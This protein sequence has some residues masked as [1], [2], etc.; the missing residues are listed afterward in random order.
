MDPRREILASNFEV[1][2][3]EMKQSS[4]QLMVSSD[5]DALLERM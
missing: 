3:G 2:S 5:T 4:D 1:S